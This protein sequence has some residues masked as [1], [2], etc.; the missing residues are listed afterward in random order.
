MGKSAIR[1]YTLAMCVALL[2]ISIAAPANAAASGGIEVIKGKRKV[3]PGPGAGEPRSANPV[4]PPPMYDDFDR[5]NASG[6]G[7]M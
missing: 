1:L 2:V 4:W 6:G 3:Q 7:G 5:R